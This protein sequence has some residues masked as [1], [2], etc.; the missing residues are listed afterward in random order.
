MIY[1]YSMIFVTGGT[2]LIGSHLLF[3]LVKNGEHVR[4]LKRKNSNI[5]EVKNI[6][7]YYSEKSNELFSKIEWVEGDLL[8]I[9]SLHEA[10][11]NISHVY[12]CGAFVS[13]NQQYREKII[14]TN[15]S[16]TANMV[17]AALENKIQKF[18]FVSS[19]AALGIEYE[20]E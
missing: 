7:S 15:V 18:C 20:K 13:L 17:N 4:A 10:M 9:I 6:F 8:D 12:H 16:A 11:K 19:V 3:E 1:I 14:Q 2:G 5:E